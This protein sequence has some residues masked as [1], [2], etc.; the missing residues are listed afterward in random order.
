M[1]SAILIGSSLLHSLHVLCLMVEAFKSA[2]VSYLKDVLRLLS[3]GV[4]DNTTRSWDEEAGPLW[5]FPWWCLVTLI[6]Q[7]N[8][9]VLQIIL[10]CRGEEVKYIF[11][12]LNVCL[13]L[14]YRNGE[15]QR[16][17]DWFLLRTCSISFWKL[18]LELDSNS[19]LL[20][21]FSAKFAVWEGAKL[22]TR[23]CLIGDVQKTPCNIW[24]AFSHL[25]MKP[26]IP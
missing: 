22:Y 24:I 12:H 20:V 8:L 11:Y 13:E 18:L 25:K 10:S 4:G 21:S 16:L 6:H 26:Q 19:S 23:D 9:K 1:F 17:V 14:S 5:S 7:Q 3:V 15:E 2:F